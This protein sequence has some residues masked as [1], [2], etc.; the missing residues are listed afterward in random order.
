MTGFGFGLSFLVF[1]DRMNKVHKVANLESKNY[2][3]LG[4]AMTDRVRIN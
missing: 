2:V 1:S 3:L 4:I